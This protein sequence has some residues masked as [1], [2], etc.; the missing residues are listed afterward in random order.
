MKLLV[1]MNLSPRW[2]GVPVNSRIEAAHCSTMG[3]H[4]ALDRKIMAN[5]S[6]HDYIVFTH[7]LD[8]G[9]ILAATTARSPV[10]CKSVLKMLAPP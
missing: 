9:A 4:D 2:F 8:F 3:A 10:L 1:D 6:V 7:D 5:A